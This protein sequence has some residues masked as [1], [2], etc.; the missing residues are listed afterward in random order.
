MA[1]AGPR[2]STERP[3]GLQWA[4]APGCLRVGVGSHQP[5]DTPR[6]KCKV[7]GKSRAAP[8]ASSPSLWPASA[9]PALRRPPRPTK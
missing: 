9:L 5:Q 1:Q 6:W 8:A 7:L 4:L 2:G 3:Q